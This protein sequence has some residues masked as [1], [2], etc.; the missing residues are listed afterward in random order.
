MEGR[1]MNWVVLVVLM[2]LQGGEPARPY[3][4]QFKIEH[5]RVEMPA[6]TTGKSCREAANE[7]RGRRYGSTEGHKLV[8][9]AECKQEDL[10]ELAESQ[11]TE[12]QGFSRNHD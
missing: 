2:Q 4:L 8:A 12:R 9:F 1:A 5:H 6:G 11:K 3:D 7:I 10:V